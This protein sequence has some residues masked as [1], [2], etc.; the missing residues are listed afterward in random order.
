MTKI[1]QSSLVSVL[2]F[3]IYIA[4]MNDVIEK[5]IQVNIK[6]IEKKFYPKDVVHEDTIM[7]RDI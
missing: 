1:N 5:L 2:N 4:T 6:K 7:L 3:G